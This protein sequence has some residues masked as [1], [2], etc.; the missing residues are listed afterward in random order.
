MRFQRCFVLAALIGAGAGQPS[1][2]H[3]AKADAATPAAQSV[4]T[5]NAPGAAK[6]EKAAAGASTGKI[7]LAGSDLLKGDCA[8]ELEKAAANTAL[9][10][11]LEG[12]LMGE[13]F[14]RDSRATGALLFLPEKTK[15]RE[16]AD[17]RWIATP[18]AYQAIVVAVA[19]DNKVERLDLG[20]LARIF[21]VRQGESLR[22][23]SEVGGSGLSLPIH[24]IATRYDASVSTP[25]FRNRVLH[26]QDFRGNT[27]FFGSDA[28]TAA[29]L[30]G[31]PASI[32]VLATP[33]QEA[34]NIR[35]VPLASEAISPSAYLPTAENLQTGD[36]PLML[37]LYLVIPRDSLNT[38]RPL[39]PALL[40]DGF[41]ESLQRRGFIP[42]EKKM[43]KNFQ[44]A[45]DKMR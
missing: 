27:S 13:K 44:E 40:G 7:V 33:P 22:G 41:A 31:S 5:P 25:M 45:L 29:Y 1:L 39:L 3:R 34:A 16:I 20:I 12:S 26:D 32:A 10:L 30:A 36:Y 8:S 23:W 37:P 4:A 28:E 11:T 19:R 21:G 35:I 2:F 18:L 42:V 43:R 38:I 14:L 9:K 24:P 17:G 15:V 6:D